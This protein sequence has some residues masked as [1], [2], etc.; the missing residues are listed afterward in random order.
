MWS[1]N[2]HQRR[3]DP[4]VFESSHALSPVHSNAGVEFVILNLFVQP[5][6]QMAGRVTSLLLFVVLAVAARFSSS[7]TMRSMLRLRRPSAAS[8]LQM[9]IDTKLTPLPSPEDERSDTDNRWRT[10]GGST[11]IPVKRDK[12]TTRP[13][14][15]TFD[16]YNTLIE[17]SQSMGRW[18]REALNTACDMTIRLPRPVFFTAA[19]K[20]AYDE[21]SITHPCFGTLSNGE[22]TSKQWWYEVVRNTYRGTKELTT[23]DHD[24]LE[25]LLPA[26]FN[27]LYED[28]FNSAEGWLV[29]EDVE[30]TL[31]KLKEWRDQGS[32][33]KIGVISNSDNRLKN[34]LRGTHP[35]LPPPDLL[36]PSSPRQPF[37]SSQLSSALYVLLIVVLF[38]VLCL[39]RTGTCKTFGLRVDIR[40]KSV[41]KAAKGHL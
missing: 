10:P 22:L 11:I 25:T 3:I 35:L 28:I 23:I 9:C 19:F 4:N 17:P 5:K 6:D 40:R 38:V 7:I 27:I 1:C 24:E 8:T 37:I 32:G 41:G 39:D 36:Y 14:L 34:V 18:Y 26:V 13:E 16:A 21:M 33:P 30:Y 15:I 2:N 20:K 29:K 31:I 12:F